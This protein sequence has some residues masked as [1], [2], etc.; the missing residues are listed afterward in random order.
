[1]S[2]LDEAREYLERARQITA[3]TLRATDD[4]LWPSADYAEGYLV[5]R[6]YVMDE[7][8]EWNAPNGCVTSREASALRRVKRDASS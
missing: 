8:G 3:A 7:G 2:H 6:G 4:A 5:G 1:M